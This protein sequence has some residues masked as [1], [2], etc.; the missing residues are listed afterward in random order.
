MWL[1]D[2]LNHVEERLIVAGNIVMVLDAKHDAPLSGPASAFPQRSY[3]PGPALVERNTWVV[4]PGEKANQ[5]TIEVACHP[6]QLADVEYLHLP[7]RNT[8]LFAAEAEVV[9]AGQASDLEV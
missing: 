9:V 2:F 8:R 1:I 5:L 3:A 6:A 7:G 4:E